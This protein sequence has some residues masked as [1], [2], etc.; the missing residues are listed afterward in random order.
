MAA[1]NQALSRLEASAVPPLV[2]A[3]GVFETCRVKAGRVLHLEAHLLRLGA[4]L[5]TVGIAAKSLAEVRRQLKQSAQGIQDGYVRVALRRTWNAQ[6]GPKILVHRHPGVPYSKKKIMRGL[7]IRT[8][9]TPWPAGEPALAQVKGSERLSGILGRIEAGG[10]TE[11]LR[12]GPLGLLTE[13]TASNL[14]LVKAGVLL[15]PPRWVG[16][17]EGVTRAQVMQTARRLKMT[18]REMP[19]TRHDLFNAEEAFLTNVLMPVFPIRSVD[20]RRIGQGVP[21]PV[22]QKLMRLIDHP[23]L[24]EHK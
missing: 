14:F 12:L 3:S 8:V 10:A 7:E 16:V 9:P 21:G 19:I 1:S 20:G 23:S 24:R 18:V 17:L 4:S 2:D 5:K 22:T 15:T 13:G 11:A 6:G